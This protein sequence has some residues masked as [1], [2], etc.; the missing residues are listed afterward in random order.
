MNFFYMRLSSI[1][2]VPSATQ[3]KGLS[4][5]LVG[6]FISFS[7]NLSKPSNKAPPPVKTI[8]LSIMSAAS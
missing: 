6:T 4:A 3:V 8:P 5:T 7:I 1:I 2:P